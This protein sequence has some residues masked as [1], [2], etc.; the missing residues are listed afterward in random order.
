MCNLSISLF[1]Y[2]VSALTCLSSH[3]SIKLA[4]A[5]ELRLILSRKD[6]VC[7]LF[8]YWC[9]LCQKKFFSFFLLKV[10]ELQRYWYLNV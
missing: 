3:Y 9:Y 6:N 2:L 10:T 5:H 8:N 7:L 1:F 4:E